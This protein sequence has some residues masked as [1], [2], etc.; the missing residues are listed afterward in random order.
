MAGDFV[1]PYVY[2]QSLQS[3]LFVTLWTIAHQTPP[4][5]GIL[6]ARMLEW[7]AM[8][9]SREFSQPMDWTQVSCIAGGF[10][11]IWATWEAHYTF[12]WM[13]KWVSPLELS[14]DWSQVG[15]APK[16]C[17]SFPYRPIRFSFLIAQM[18]RLKDL[19]LR[20][21]MWAGCYAFTGLRN[22]LIRA[23]LGL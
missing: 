9:S 8:P 17:S 2:A 6:Q 3:W 1:S 4:S 21:A 14:R 15:M 11:T 22:K 16:L 5:M 7:V 12:L 10:S 19:V 20:R 13:R 23:S 18:G